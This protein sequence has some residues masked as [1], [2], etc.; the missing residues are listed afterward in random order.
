MRKMWGSILG[1]DTGLHL[2]CCMAA[3]GVRRWSARMGR[4]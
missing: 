3:G 2:E 1:M 4:E